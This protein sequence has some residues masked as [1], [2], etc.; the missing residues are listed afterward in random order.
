MYPRCF[1]PG[2]IDR[3]SSSND[4]HLTSTDLNLCS[5]MGTVD[6]AH[7]CVQISNTKY[8][9][10]TREEPS[11]IIMGCTPMKRPSA[12][13]RLST[14]D[15]I[16]KKNLEIISSPLETLSGSD[17]MEDSTSTNNIFNPTIRLFKDNSARWAIDFTKEQANLVHNIRPSLFDE[18]A[19]SERTLSGLGASQPNLQAYNIVPHREKSREL[20]LVHTNMDDSNINPS[21]RIFSDNSADRLHVNEG[22]VEA[23]GPMSPSLFS[24]LENSD[25]DRKLWGWWANKPSQAPNTKGSSKTSSSSTAKKPSKKKKKKREIDEGHVC[26]PTDDDILFGRG[27]YTNSHPG[28]IRFREKALELRPVYER[29][30]KEEK[31]KISQILLDSIMSDGARFLEKGQDGEWH[32]VKGNGARKKASQALRERIKGTPRRSRTGVGASLTSSLTSVKS[33]NSQSPGSAEAYLSH[34]INGDILAV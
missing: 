25:S 7:G 9:P 18:E 11:H 26:V 2:K 10:A 19:N 13:A 28:N 1:G 5:R 31:F 24:N 23:L 29:S 3:R 8:A 15:S 16:L 34:E 12:V 30:S 21:I 4:L 32:Q 20:H 14:D 6:F 22:Q 17:I 33:V 27:G